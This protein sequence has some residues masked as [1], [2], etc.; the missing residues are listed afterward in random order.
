MDTSNP[1]PQLAPS[2]RRKKPNK[3]YTLSSHVL[4][5]PR[6]TYLN[7]VPLNPTTKLESL[8]ATTV[9]LALLRALS[10]YLGEH[11]AA[12]PVD[13]L[14]IMHE[15]PQSG[16]YLRV[17]HEDGTAFVAALASTGG[18]DA[19]LSFRIRQRSDWP[20]AMVCPDPQALFELSTDS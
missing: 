13:I 3:S 2:K 6:W 19:G 18:V 8:D 12:I 11:G 5:P 1:H 14:S 10:T 7:L 9:R 16:V 4:S 20:A 17:P 15:G